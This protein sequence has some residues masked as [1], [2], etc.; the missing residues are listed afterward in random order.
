[1]EYWRTQYDCRRKEQQ[2][3]KYLQYTCRYIFPIPTPIAAF[4]RDVLPAPRS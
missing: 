1:M 3:N 4:A 2:L